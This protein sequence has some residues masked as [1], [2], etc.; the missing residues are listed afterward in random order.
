MLFR[1]VYSCLQLEQSQNT[2]TLVAVSI[3]CNLS[4]LPI[5]S[6]SQLSVD[7][8]SM[9]ISDGINLTINFLLF[10][11]RDITKISALVM[12]LKLL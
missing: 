5:F 9:I 11:F 2:C 3:Y 7:H 1:L 10:T 8:S 6:I 12:H 4:E